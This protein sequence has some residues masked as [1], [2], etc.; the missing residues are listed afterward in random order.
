MLDAGAGGGLAVEPC[1]ELDS[2]GPRR[3]RRAAPGSASAGRDPGRDPRADPA[4]SA[5]PP[6]PPHRSRCARP[7]GTRPAA[8]AEPGSALDA[9]GDGSQSACVRRAAA[10]SSAREAGPAASPQQHA[11]DSSR[12]CPRP[13]SR[14]RP[15]PT[16]SAGR[17][18]VVE[19]AA[20]AVP[21]PRPHHRVRGRG[22]SIGECRHRARRRA[23]SPPGR[24]EGI[25]DH[26]QFVVPR[27]R[28]VADSAWSAAARTASPRR[29]QPGR[30]GAV[31]T[32]GGVRHGRRTPDRAGGSVDGVRPVRRCAASCR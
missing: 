16:P 24:L 10:G 7:T 19:G 21:D 9:T 3:G 26:G 25:D 8:R 28:G 18:G 20:N 11:A 15:G 12:R 1:A 6:A 5:T 27:R 29:A 23:R 22:R 17:A 32:I 30:P 2:V 4:P 14:R 31:L 13:G